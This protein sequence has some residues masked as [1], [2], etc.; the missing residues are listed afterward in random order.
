MDVAGVVED[1]DLPHPGH[2]QQHVLVVDEGL[3]S[4]V[5]GLAVVPLGPVEAIQQGALSILLPFQQWRV[6]YSPTGRGDV[7]AW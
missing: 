4:G 3:V 1:L 7:S 2:A 6:R 5:Q